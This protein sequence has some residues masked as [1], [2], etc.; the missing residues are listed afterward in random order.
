MSRL[1]VIVRPELVVGFQLAGVN[2]YSA[3][4]VETAQDLIRG[5]LDTGETG[6]VAIDDG[7]L[8]YME[9]PLMRRL[10]T[11]EKLLY[12]AIPGGQALG[13]MA[14]ARHRIAAL[15]RQAIGFYITFK[16]EEAEES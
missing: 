3:K 2:A 12:L 9:R 16:G 7:L 13:P 11:S 15:I 6:L 4:T 1:M 5:W 10:E 8:E 14:S